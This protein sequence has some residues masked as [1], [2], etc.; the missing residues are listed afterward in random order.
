MVVAG[1]AGVF[2]V[3]TELS[4]KYGLIAAAT[5]SLNGLRGVTT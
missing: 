1:F 3:G 2:V 4:A 5:A